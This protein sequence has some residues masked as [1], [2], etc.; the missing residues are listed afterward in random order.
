M[1][2]LLLASLLGLSAAAGSTAR[3]E[4]DVP[5]GYGDV[6][7]PL[8]LQLMSAT[9]REAFVN[10]VMNGFRILAR[11]K[12]EATRADIELARDGARAQARAAAVSQ[13]VALDLNGDGVVER[14][15]AM[16]AVATRASDQIKETRAETAMKLDLDGDGKLSPEE[17][18]KARPTA[19]RD[20]AFDK[21]GDLYL[22]LMG[23]SSTLRA[24]D[25]T[26]MAERAFDTVDLDGDT[27]LS[28]E[29]RTAFRQA[30]G[31]T[32]EAFRPAPT[33]PAEAPP[34]RG[35]DE[36]VYVVGVYEG[37]T[38]TPEAPHGPV[39]AITLDRPGKKVTLL[40][41]SYDPIRWTIKTTSGTE[42]KELRSMSYKPSEFVV[43]GAARPA[44]PF[45]W[46]GDC[47]YQAD[48]PQLRSI[49]TSLPRW[50][51]F[52]RL[53]GFAG[54]YTAEKAGYVIDRPA[55]TAAI[56][57][58]IAKPVSIE[59]LPQIRFPANLKD[60]PGVYDLTGRRVG[61]SSLPMGPLAVDIPDRGERYVL[62]DEGFRVSKIAGGE[63]P[64]TIPVS[65]DVPPISWPSGLAYDA[66]RARLLVVTFGGEGYLYEY[67]LQTGKWR[68]M[69]SM[70]NVDVGGLFYD[71]ASDLLWTSGGG[72][73]LGLDGDGA[74]VEQVSVRSITPAEGGAAGPKP[75]LFAASLLWVDGR[76]AVA[77][78]RD[79]DQYRI[80]LV[81]LKDRTAK[82]TGVSD[83]PSSPE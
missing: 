28:P 19:G 34:K 8:R 35:D 72:K 80:Y 37:D 25:M 50:T 16:A 24:I 52:R 4:P 42:L 13:I 5:P 55:E 61:K 46:E 66:K 22:D 82:L 48:T 43:D 17:I 78:S 40:V 41:C 36:E 58:P 68:V 39:G 60:G 45:G 74:T 79:R 9:S 11:G 2:A 63:P 18:L 53:H 14:A 3:A 32:T 33:A 47:P 27:L 7:G 56:S 20:A 44:K 30:V 38:G 83:T 54:S 21:A 1:R 69:T 64:R 70:K 51:G 15:E 76:N 67:A 59:G 49:S 71:A 81:D 10:Q 29:E 31:A 77:L 65:L 62:S 57:Q 26:R 6:P 73:F 23:Q 75:L 12:P